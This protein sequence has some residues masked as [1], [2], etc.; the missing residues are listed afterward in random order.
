[1]KGIMTDG[2]S[3]QLLVLRREPVNKLGP[4]A[5]SWLQRVCTGSTAVKIGTESGQGFWSVQLGP[6]PSNFLS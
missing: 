6:L 2:E 1:M 3:D 4:Q 5:V